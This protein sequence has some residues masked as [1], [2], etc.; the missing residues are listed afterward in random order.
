ML[1][2]PAFA[3]GDPPAGAAVI[4][5]GIP[6]QLDA[7]QRTGYA[8]VFKAIHEQRWT[9]AQIQLTAMKPGPLHSIAAA[10]LYLAKG[11]PKVDNDPLLQVLANAPELPEAPAI[12]RILSSRGVVAPALPL[13]QRMIWVNA[14]TATGPATA[15]TLAHAAGA[16]RASDIEL[17]AAGAYWAARADMM[18]D[19]PQLGEGRLKNAAQL[20]ETFY[21]MLARQ[22]LGIKETQRQTEE[23]MLADWDGSGACPNR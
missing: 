3:A 7:D 23:L 2:A 14:A 10:E 5:R 18:C 20:D 16:A 15:T 1:A 22:Q 4:T 11:S 21:G 9:D 8:A 17:R 12:A 13:Q 19:R 6:S